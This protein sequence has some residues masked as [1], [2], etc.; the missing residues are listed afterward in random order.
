MTFHVNTA[1]LSLAEDEWQIE[2]RDLEVRG[3][4]LELGDGVNLPLIAIPAGEFG[5]GSPEDEPER[6]SVE[7]PRHRVRLEGVF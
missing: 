1:R 6:A 5:M 4:Q 2:R 3:R 7:G